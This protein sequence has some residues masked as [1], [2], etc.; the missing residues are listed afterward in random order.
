MVGLY[1]SV[2]SLFSLSLGREE[3]AMVASKGSRELPQGLRKLTL[4]RLDYRVLD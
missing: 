3:L 2:T 1:L 4:E